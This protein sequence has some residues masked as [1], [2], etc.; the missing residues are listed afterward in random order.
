MKDVADVAKCVDYLYHPDRIN[1][2]AYGDKLGHLHFHIVPKYKD[3]AE[4]G[5]TFLMNPHKY[6]ISD[7]ECE[8]IAQ[9]MRDAYDKLI[10]KGGK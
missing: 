5:G 2:G 6:E 7:N 9:K 3:D 4:W 8:V 1:Y 10:V